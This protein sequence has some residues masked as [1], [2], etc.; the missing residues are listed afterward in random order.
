MKDRQG[1]AHID[2]VGRPDSCGGNGLCL[3]YLGGEG[4]H[5]EAPVAVYGPFTHGLVADSARQGSKAGHLRHAGPGL[6]AH[7]T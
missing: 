3:V 5:R 7:H 1:G 6:Q 2:L 4:L